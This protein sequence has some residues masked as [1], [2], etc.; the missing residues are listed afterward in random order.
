ML[1]F[2]MHCLESKRS[3]LELI[4]I[5]LANS[6]SHAH[7]MLCRFNLQFRKTRIS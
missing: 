3:K 4:G 7:A 2:S 1:G 6:F 5:Q